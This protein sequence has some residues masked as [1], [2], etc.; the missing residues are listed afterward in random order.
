MPANSHDAGHGKGGSQ[1][2]SGAD[3]SHDMEMAQPTQRT[4]QA[5]GAVLRATCTKRIDNGDPS[6]GCC[7]DKC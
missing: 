1:G 6:G 5:L 3:D 4:G 2:S 7:D